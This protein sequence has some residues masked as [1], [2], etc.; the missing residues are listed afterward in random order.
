M[1]REKYAPATFN[2]IEQVQL[3]FL[4]LNTLLRPEKDGHREMRCQQGPFAAPQN[5]CSQTNNHPGTATHR[6]M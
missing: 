2:L 4:R 1:P 3:P 5:A 6:T